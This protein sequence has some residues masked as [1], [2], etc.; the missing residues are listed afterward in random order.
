MESTNV[1]VT[2]SA[3]SAVRIYSRFVLSIYD[4]YVFWFISPL[5]FKCPQRNLVEFYLN[6]LSNNHLEIGVGTGYLLRKCDEAG[7]IGALALLDLNENCLRVTQKHLAAASPL[8]YTADILQPLPMDGRTFSSVGLNF[9]LHCV[10]GN[11]KT[12]GIAFEHI[13][14]CMEPGGEVFGTTAI[15]YAGQSK[16]AGGIM[17]IYN[18]KGIFSNQDDIEDDLVEVLAKNFAD[19]SVS[20]IGNVIFFRAVKPRK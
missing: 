7:R 19:V 2:A 5:V 4:Y 6:K 9:V 18:N 17:D 10:P 3:E 14:A 8:T 1:S 20:Q 16:L 13:A 15:Y 12:K 11:F